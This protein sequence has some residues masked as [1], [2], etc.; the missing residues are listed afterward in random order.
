MIIINHF[1]FTS[2]STLHL[3]NEFMCEQQ[4]QQVEAT[5]IFNVTIEKNS[6]DLC[7]FFF[8]QNAPD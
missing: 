1:L 2:K 3:L 7:V 6:S 8:F 4:W 5:Y